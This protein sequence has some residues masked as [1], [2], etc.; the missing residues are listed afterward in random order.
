MEPNDPDRRELM[1]AAAALALAGAG[2]A[3]A[4]APLPGAALVMPTPATPTP[5]RPGDF[6]FL[7]GQWRIR[8]QRRLPSGEWDRFE[9]EASCY[10][11]LG[12]VCSVEEL[13]IPARNFSGLGLRLLDLPRRRWTDFWVN[14]ASGVL[15]P[16]G[17][18]GSFENGA[19]LFESEEQEDG[20][21]VRYRGV[22]DLITPRSCRW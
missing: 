8:H 11:I 19:G 21:T 15:A 9:G 22:W 13:R 18:E 4:A 2:S 6:D 10:G 20:K 14:A 7:S 16:P 5:G 1:R 3:E 12:G 17:L